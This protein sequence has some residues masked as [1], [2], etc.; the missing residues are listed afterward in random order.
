M[1]CIKVNL[2]LIILICLFGCD[3][4]ESDSGATGISLERR[5]I[6]AASVGDIVIMA[7]GSNVE[8][9]WTNVDIYNVSTGV[10]EL[11][12]LTKRRGRG[13][14]V[15]LNNKAYFAGGEECNDL[16][17]EVGNCTM[18]SL[19]E[20]YDV[21][22]KSWTVSNLS[23]ARMELSAAV[24]IDG[25]VV[26]AGGFNTSTVSNVVDIYNSNTDTWSNTTIPVGRFGMTA[27]GVNGKV[28]F[29]G[30]AISNGGATQTN[31][32]DIFE[33]STNT[34]TLETL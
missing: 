5:F 14:A 25:Y 8:G 22:S 18:S 7:G 27:I 26:F 24:T 23:E 28:Y 3:K 33:P 12:Y 4:S 2:I 32:V 20:I 6:M 9:Y 10:L 15:A 31:R 11:Q 21:T 19:V 30:G 16:G 1:K 29:A 34:W 13:A 17:W